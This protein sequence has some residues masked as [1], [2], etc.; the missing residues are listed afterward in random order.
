MQENI[1]LFCAREDSAEGLDRGSLLAAAASEGTRPQEGE[2][3]ANFTSLEL[4]YVA[5]E[6]PTALL[7]QL[8]I[9]GKFTSDVLSGTKREVAWLAF[10]KEFMAVW[11]CCS[12]KFNMSSFKRD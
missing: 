11:I 8:P 12:H 3:E 6:I 9:T 5:I 2:D 4:L 10:F 1:K 7:V